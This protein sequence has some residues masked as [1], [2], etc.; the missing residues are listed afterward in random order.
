MHG[1]GGG[2]LS[3]TVIQTA[4]CLHLPS[5]PTAASHFS[6]MLMLH[7]CQQYQ[8]G[9]SFHHPIES[10]H[11]SPR[12]STL[13]TPGID[14]VWRCVRRNSLDHTLCLVLIGLGRPKKVSAIVKLCLWGGYCE[15]KCLRSFSRIAFL[16]VLPP[17]F[18]TK[19]S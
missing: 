10:Y 18:L 2:G 3:L 14:L 6:L 5:L 9:L 12:S 17:N 11:P 19:L 13:P 15:A 16:S 4:L 8:L 1:W 7:A